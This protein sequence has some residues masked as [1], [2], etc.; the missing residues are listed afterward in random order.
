MSR[1]SDN[2]NFNAVSLGDEV[3]LCDEPGFF[4]VDIVAGDNPEV[5][6]SSD[7][8]SYIL[9]RS[10]MKKSHRTNEGRIVWTCDKV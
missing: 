1:L 7:H 6:V 8:E 3:V 2:W 9:L 4:V 10:D 5:E